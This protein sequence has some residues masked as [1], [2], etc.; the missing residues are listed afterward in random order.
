MMEYSAVIVAAGSGSRVG[1]GY[2]KMLFK[3]KNGNTIL[4]ETMH[5]FE[6]DRRCKEIV[7]VASKQD[8]EAF[9]KLCKEDHILLVE[10]G[11]TRQESVWNGLQKVHYPYVMIHD[12]ARPWLPMD[13]IDRIVETLESARACL[14][15]VPVKDTI[16]VVENGVVKHTPQR[17]TL[18]Q[19]QTPQAFSTQDIVNAYKEANRLGVQATDDAQIMELC[20]NEDVI[21]VEGSY[22]NQKVT[23]IEDLKGR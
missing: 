21:V 23:T 9:S 12:G 7:V 11:A 10:G 20:G 17:S 5:I 16:K 1:L 22:E 8:K 14:L 3:L 13:C 19:A 18:W 4:E 15:M 6:K 2:N